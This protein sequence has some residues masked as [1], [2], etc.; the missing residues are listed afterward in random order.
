MWRG[1]FGTWFSI[2]NTLV[3]A[4]PL[5]L[6]ALCTALPAALGLVVIG[7][8]GAVVLGGLGAAVTALWVAGSPPWLAMPAMAVAGM[9]AGALLIGVVGALRHWRGVNETIASLLVSYLAISVFNHLVRGPLRDPKTFNYP[10]TFPIPREFRVGDI[11][12]IDVHWGLLIGL[13]ACVGSWLLIDRT[14]FGFAARFTGQSLAAAKLGGLN[15][16]RLTITLCALGGGAAGLAGMF[17][18]AAVI[19]R[20]NGALHVGYGF[21][22][23]LVAF[24][25]RHRPLAVIPAAIL[26]GGVRASS[27]LV[28][29]DFGLPDATITVFEGLLFLAILG[30]EYFRGRWQPGP[31]V[32]SD[33]R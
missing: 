16:G 28:Q 12:G 30:A 29:R 18:A 31:T 17:E 33:E 14:A 24:V 21:S 32:S 15:I 26:V 25:A 19:G 23:I 4:A 13:V 7:G 20:A 10:G 8:E 6:I 11:P 3:R 5:M 1:A 27:G 22:A 9:L 2:E